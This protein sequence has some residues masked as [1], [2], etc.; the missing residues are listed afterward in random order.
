AGL[1]L[2]TPA[3]FNRRTFVPGLGFNNEA[4]GAAFGAPM[5]TPVM[6]R[7]FDAVH[8]LRANMRSQADREDFELIKEILRAREV[9]A[10]REA[11]IRSYL[12]ELRRAA[13]IKDLRREVNA[14]LRRQVIE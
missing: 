5:N 13:T 2:Q 11:R 9:P 10:A 14:S 8:V 12:E 1:E 6:V 7:T 3:P 4:I